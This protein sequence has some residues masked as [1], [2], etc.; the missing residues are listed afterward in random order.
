[1]P[2]TADTLLPQQLARNRKM[3]HEHT[4]GGETAI[5]AVRAKLTGT[6]S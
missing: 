4:A 5:S 6:R 3:D 1:M 2:G